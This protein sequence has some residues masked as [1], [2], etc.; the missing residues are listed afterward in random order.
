MVAVDSEQYVDWVR[1]RFGVTVPGGAGSAV[2]DLLGS[3]VEYTAWT[4]WT[5]RLGEP[6]VVLCMESLH[7]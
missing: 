6:D 2:A 3:R 7:R 5:C 1:A 4:R